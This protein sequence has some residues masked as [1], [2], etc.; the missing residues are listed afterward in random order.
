MRMLVTL[1]KAEQ[2]LKTLSRHYSVELFKD[3][4]LELSNDTNLCVLIKNNP[5][6]DDVEKLVKPLKTKPIKYGNLFIFKLD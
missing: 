4:D 2:I 3:E 1:T 5:N 6:I